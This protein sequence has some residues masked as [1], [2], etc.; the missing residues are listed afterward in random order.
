M[1]EPLAYEGKE[2]YIFISY[3]HLDK[4]IVYPILNRLKDDNYRFWY[5]QALYA[6]EEWD[7]AIAAKAEASE[8]F[9]AFITKNYLDSDNCKD[10]LKYAR[11]LNKTIFIIYLQNTALSGGM[12]M[13]M[14]R[15][16]AIYKTAYQNEEDFYTALYAHAPK[17]IES[18]HSATPEEHENTILN[19]QL[20]EKTGE[21]VVAGVIDKTIERVVIPSTYRGK[22]VTKINAAAF[23]NCEKLS[24]VFIPDSISVIGG[25]AFWQCTSLPVVTIPESVLVIEKYAF[26]Y[27]TS[28]TSITI[29]ANVMSIGQGVVAGCISLATIIVDEKNPIHKGANNCL[30]N[31][32][33]KTLISGCKNSVIP[34]DGSVVLIGEGAFRDCS[35]LISVSIP[36]SVVAIDSLA[37]CRCTRLKSVSFGSNSRLT[38]I[39][40][41]SFA[42]CADLTAFNFP[43]SVTNIE[44]DA[45]DSCKSLTTINVPSKVTNINS[46]VFR[47]CTNLSS[48]LLPDGLTSIGESAFVHCGSLTSIA[49]PSNVSTICNGAFW[50]CSALTSVTFGAD[51]QLTTI[52]ENAFAHCSNLNYILIPNSVTF[53]GS[54]AFE[55]SG[56][57]DLLVFRFYGTEKQWANIKKGK[58]WDLKKVFFCLP[59]EI[60][61]S[62]SCCFRFSLDKKKNEYTFAG[63]INWAGAEIVIPPTYQ[64]K[65]VTSIGKKAFYKCCG[66]SSITI[67]NTITHIGTKALMGCKGLS[68]IYFQG[69]VEQWKSIKKAPKWDEQTHRYDVF[70]IDGN[71]AM[72][73]GEST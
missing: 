28:L 66:F 60:S 31:S 73:K 70:C 43:S 65:L 23:E 39:G 5:D 35:G 24:S 42:H 6:S 21:Y 56:K 30:I 46:S 10:E 36:D 38:K 64:A 44:N 18:C 7:E 67:P 58:E 52:E 68:V 1:K 62:S 61:I 63:V 55:E 20:D 26:A 59:S 49:I 8:I 19:L 17:G 14:N 16:Q 9:L 45:F 47:W 12:A 48:V 3:A 4:E 72:F 25:G 11:D 29:P 33:T 40:V 53:I 51:S 41:S 37:F 54:N 69:T 22:P 2:P 34:T 27:C 15:I 32:N 50:D 57:A 13:R 71:I